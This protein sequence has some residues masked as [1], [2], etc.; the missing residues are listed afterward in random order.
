MPPAV[1]QLLLVRPMSVDIDSALTDFRKSLQFARVDS[2]SIQLDVQDRGCPHKRPTLPK[3]KMA[4]YIFA[5][6]DRVLKVGK[7]G[8]KTKQRFSTHHHAPNSSPSNLAKSLLGDSTGD[9]R[10]ASADEIGPWMLQHL[11]RIDILLSVDVGMPI[12]AYL[13]AFLHCRLRP[14]YEGFKSQKA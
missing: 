4:I 13:E 7:V 1:A 3:R 12:L 9:W 2:K 8:P 5:L 11:H 10:N 14:V 6:G